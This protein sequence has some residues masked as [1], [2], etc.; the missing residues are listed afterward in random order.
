[1]GRNVV[2]QET[3]K[4]GGI[5]G[6]M[7]FQNFQPPKKNIEDLRD[8]LLVLIDLTLDLHFKHGLDSKDWFDDL[9]D[10]LI[11]LNELIVDGNRAK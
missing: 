11:E 8:E 9:T 6:Y 7:Y 2:R 10:E 4:R 5:M 3:D 1:M